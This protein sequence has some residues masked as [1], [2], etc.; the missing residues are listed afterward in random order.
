MIALELC[1]IIKKNC[2]LILLPFFIY[3]SFL[4]LRAKNKIYIEEF[5]YLAN[6]SYFYFGLQ[7]YFKYLILKRLFI[8]I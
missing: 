8:F 7:I 2:T 6:F 1:Q 4:I 5:S 3:N